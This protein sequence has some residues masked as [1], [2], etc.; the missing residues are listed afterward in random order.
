MRYSI[1]DASWIEY[2]SN[3][4]GRRHSSTVIADNKLYI[5][6]G[7]SRENGYWQYYNLSQSIDLS[8][9]VSVAS[10]G[11]KLP[12]VKSLAQNYPNPFNPT[13]SIRFFLPAS[14]LIK[15]TVF[16]LKGQRIRQL[17]E[18]AFGLGDHEI[19]WDGMNDSGHALPSGQYMYSLETPDGIQSKKMILLR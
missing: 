6:A 10:Q 5:I 12:T 19:Q 1:G 15:L 16:D 11:L 14:G 13:T 8:G 4:I 7:N 18:G 17:S 9:V 2:E 3:F